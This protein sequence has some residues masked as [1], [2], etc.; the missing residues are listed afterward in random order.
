LSRWEELTQKT[1]K[2][3]KEG[4]KPKAP[5]SA[6]MWILRLLPTEDV[7]QRAHEL[8]NES[9]EPVMALLLV[10]LSLIHAKNGPLPEDELWGYLQLLGIRHHHNHPVFGN[11]EKVIDQHVKFGNETSVLYKHQLQ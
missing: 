2:S 7:A 8:R 11:P 1:K 6:S 4:A 3:Q 9:E 5:P 10:I